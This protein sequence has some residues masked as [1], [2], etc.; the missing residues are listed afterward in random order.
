MYAITERKSRAPVVPK[1]ALRIEAH[2]E[3]KAINGSVQ[4]SMW[5]G[6][7]EGTLLFSLSSQSSHEAAV[8]LAKLRETLSNA[9]PDMIISESFCE[10]TALRGS[11]QFS[12]RKVN[13]R[14]Q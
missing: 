13:L 7:R 2:I 4:V 5:T 12:Y 11:L 10:S 14:E 6:E 9:N 1:K 8:V 3:R